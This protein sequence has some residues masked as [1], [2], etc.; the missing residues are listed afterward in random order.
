MN[1]TF[2]DIQ[3]YFNWYKT[4]YGDSLRFDG[5]LSLPERTIASEKV[6]PVKIAQPE[7]VAEPVKK[8]RFDENLIHQ[9]NLQ[10]KKFYHEINNCEKCALGKTRQNFVFGMGNPT[11]DLMFI[12]EAPGQEE[13]LKGLPFVGRAGQLLDKMLFA[14]KLK[15]DEVYIANILKC[16]PPNNRDPL[17]DEV[18]KCEPYLKKQIEMIGPKVI[19]ALGRISA[20][21]LLK[22]S[23]PLSALRR[24]THYYE[25][26]PFIVTYHPAALLRNPRWKSNAWDDLQKLKSFFSF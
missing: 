22:K 12:G 8:L 20:Q 2:K 19:V 26:I 11:A 10:L 17:P 18:S 7:P 21:V 14:M 16:R 6:N 4:V 24:D 9:N 25:K 13:D 15:R 1:E 3:E 23:D 5:D